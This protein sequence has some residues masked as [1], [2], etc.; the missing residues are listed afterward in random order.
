MSKICML[1][2]KR[3]L[4]GNNVSNSNRKTRKKFSPNIHTQKFWSNEKNKFIKI[5]ISNKGLRIVN[6]Y[7]IDYFISSFKV[8]N[9]DY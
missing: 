7:G 2:G 1:T 8:K 6:K 9:F 4:F 3:V 5:R